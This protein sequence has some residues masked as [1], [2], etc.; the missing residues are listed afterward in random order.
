MEDYL[1]KCVN[2]KVEIAAS[3]L[4][5]EPE[6]AEVCLRVHPEACEKKR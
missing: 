2:T 5:M 6:E 3:E 1:Q 4:L